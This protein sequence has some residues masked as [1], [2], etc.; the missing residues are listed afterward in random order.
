[1]KIFKTLF[2]LAVF[3]VTAQVAS[4]QISIGGYTLS[5]Q[6]TVD[7]S[8]VA[9]TM[10]AKLCPD[11]VTYVGRVGPSCAFAACPS[12]CLDLKTDLRV[13]S[14]D[15]GTGGE[16]SKL[17]TFLAPQYLK[18][19]PTGRFLGLTRAAI[20]D[21]QKQY[22]ISPA[23]GNVG[24]LTRAK[25]KELTCGGGGTT[26]T[27]AINNISPS[28]AKVGET[29]ALSGPGLNSGSDYILFNGWRIET[30]GSKALNRV[31]FVVPQ[32]ISQQVN[33]I[34]APCPDIVTMVNPGTYTVQV[35]NNLGKSNTVNLTVTDGTTVPPVDAAKISWVEPTS[36][37]VGTSVVIY[38]YNLFRP[39]TKILFDG[40][41]IPGKPVYSK[42]AGNF[43]SALEF[44]VPE[45][46]SYQCVRL[47]PT[48]P[49]PA[50]A[51]RQVLP[52]TYELAVENKFGRDSVKFEVLGNVVSGKPYLSYAN[53]SQASV[54]TEIAVFGENLNTG[55]E[56]V[57]FGGSEVFPLTSALTDRR[58]MV[59]FKI[60]EYITPCGYED[61]VLCR[62]VAQLVTPGKY[63]IVVKN[64]NG[65]SNTLSF[66]VTSGG[67]TIAPK[68]NSLTPS[69]GLVGTEVVIRGEG[70]NVGGDQIYFG[71]SLV[72]PSLS[73]GADTVNMLRFR[74][75]QNITPCGI[76]GQN[77][78][79]IATQP[80]T[81]GN[82]EV[83]VVNNRG[84]SNI[85]SFT[86]TSGTTNPPTISGVSGPQTLNIGQTGTWTVT[87]SNPNGGNLSYSVVWGDEEVSP[88]VV[89]TQG[90]AQQTAIFT[91]TYSQGGMY[92]PR[93]F[94]T[95][96]SGQSASASISVNVGNAS[97][98]LSIT[99][100]RVWEYAFI[101]GSSMGM[102]RRLVWTTTGAQSCYA[103]G[104][105]SGTQPVNGEYSIGFMSQP[106]TYTLTCYNNKGLSVS[107][108][109]T[110]PTGGTTQAP[111]ISSVSPSYA[112]VD[113][114]VT[115]SGERLNTGSPKIIFGNGYIT[116]SAIRV[117]DS[118]LYF[119]VPS[120][121]S[122]YCAP[123][124][125]CTEDMISVTP[126]SYPVKVMNSYGTSN[127]VNVTVTTPSTNPPT[128]SSLTPSVGA[129]GAQV[130]ISGTNLNPSTDFVWFGGIKFAP[131]RASGSANTLVFYV[132]TTLFQCDVPSS[133]ECLAVYQPTPLG[134]Y[135]VKVENNAGVVSNALT[136]QVTSN[137]SNLDR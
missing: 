42:R 129:T 128:I 91:H 106:L 127:S 51:A 84:T 87:A 92:M 8:A 9:C 70:I 75:P 39:E 10:D 13:N 30:D 120:M 28:Y 55:S 80:V 24:P 107:K 6:T 115:L 102:G 16:V 90:V 35:V 72:A 85:L 57:Y 101:N 36:A 38:G 58:G 23:F 116:P 98:D 78:C 19:E 133:Q 62:M 56:K 69:A 134:S 83:A 99:S 21:F 114:E 49:C 81:P 54:G 111:V 68:L 25:I 64:K 104:A 67:T 77:L 109:V 45:S 97:G 44:V 122:R 121:M 22:G 125:Y 124:L 74:V 103:S 48:D 71:G 96:V 76:G 33:C 43:S 131:N 41:S 94:V 15:A 52:G 26:Q 113:G 65:L 46:L 89:P 119:T 14:T 112:V 31:A 105:W 100:F 110:E 108:S 93:F 17:Q 34:Q 130:S 11:G 29:V 18:V 7:T 5:S 50:L 137:G 53:P 1:M 73:S 123:G 12:I 37:K 126:G 59:R 47:K 32:Y 61:G 20:V 27:L 79:R 3:F 4:A 88:I 136:Y 82:Y 40:F 63:D 60:P 118:T 2:A 95:N 135:T 117:N 132:P 86:V 66:T